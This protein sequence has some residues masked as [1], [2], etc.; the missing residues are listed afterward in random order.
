MIINLMRG[1]GWRGLAVM[2]GDDLF[3]P[4]LNMSKAEIIAYALD[5]RLEWHEDSTND[6]VKYLRNYVRYRYVQRMTPHERQQWVSLYCSQVKL[7]DG[8]DTELDLLLPTFKTDVGYSRHKLIMG[9]SQA[10][11]QVIQ[12]I[13]SAPLERSTIDQLWHFVCTARSGKSF[14]QGGVVFRATTRDL[15]VSTSDIC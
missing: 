15:I 12:R 8:V 14:I 4:M 10:F 3:R 11:T 13:V 2:G 9:G 5:H 1:T 7:R 6:N